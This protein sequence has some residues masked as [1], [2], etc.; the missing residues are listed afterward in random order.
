MQEVIRN[1]SNQQ[2][3]TDISSLKIPQLRHPKGNYLPYATPWMLSNLHYT[4][5]EEHLRTGDS[6]CR[7]ENHLEIDPQRF[8]AF[9][10]F[11]LHKHLCI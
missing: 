7:L 11:C 9:N 10:L 5:F 6:G 8:T 3:V 4:Y 2:S 1:S